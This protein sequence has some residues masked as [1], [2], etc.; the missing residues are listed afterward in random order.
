MLGYAALRVLSNLRPARC[1]LVSPPASGARAHGLLIPQKIRRGVS[2]MPEPDHDR[3]P[4][5]PDQPVGQRRGGL[6]PRSAQVRHQLPTKQRAVRDQGG[7]QRSREVHSTGSRQY[8]VPPL[9]GCALG[10]VPHLRH[11]LSVHKPNVWWRRPHVWALSTCPIRR[12][13]NG[14]RWRALEG[15]R[16]DS[17]RDESG[18]ARPLAPLWTPHQT[19]K[20]SLHV[21]AAP[22][23]MH[24]PRDRS[25]GDVG[26]YAPLKENTNPF[27][28]RSLVSLHPAGSSRRAAD[29]GQATISYGL[30]INTPPADRANSGA[31]SSERRPKA[32]SSRPRRTAH[33]EITASHV[34]RTWRATW[35]RPGRHRQT[36]T[37]MTPVIPLPSSAPCVPTMIHR[38]LDRGSAR[39]RMAFVTFRPPAVDSRTGIPASTAQRHW[40]LRDWPW[41]RKLGTLDRREGC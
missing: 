8:K 18:A 22:R 16:R 4:V 13:A 17:G 37:P 31:T 27:V 41:P 30:F 23:R 14:A 32:T 24:G 20:K 29:R 15:D 1:A 38:A 12:T 19:R 25:R 28:K 9:H 34:S 10:S 35:A 33:A 39:C 5:V 3:P 40:T 36:P 7:L 11:R 26:Y 21:P 2:N 6:L